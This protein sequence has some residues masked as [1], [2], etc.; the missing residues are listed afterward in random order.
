MKTIQDSPEHH[1]LTFIDKIKRDSG[2]W[3]G[4]RIALSRKIDHEDMISRPE[5]IEG[6]LHKLRKESEA[7]LTEMNAGLASYSNATAY[8]F[9]D[10]DIVLLLRVQNN[11]EHDKV[12]E[13]F[14]RTAAKYGARLC[15]Y[16]NLAKDIYSYQKLADERFLFSRRVKAYEAM[17]DMN[18]MLSIPLRRQRRD[19]AVVLIVEDDRFTASYASNLLNKDYDVVHAKT[20]EEAI[21]SYMEHAPDA[22]FLDIHL[23]G[24]NGHE[25][26]RALRKIDPEGFIVMLSV[27]TVKQNIVISTQLGAAGFLKKPFTKERLIAA[28]EKSP[29]VRQLKQKS[30]S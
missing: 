22:V 15:E 20:G 10:C 21:L 3:V 28:V 12:R 6:K 26:L 27:D 1:F 8:V 18:R 14:Q 13:F 19:D 17:A 16:A 30:G 7:V 11:T 2:G 29:F 4:I 5:H 9:T 24:L 23:P 25:T